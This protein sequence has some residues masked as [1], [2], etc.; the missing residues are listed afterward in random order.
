MISGRAEAYCELPDVTFGIAW[1]MAHFF[2]RRPGLWGS[3][4]G[5]KPQAG[6]GMLFYSYMRTAALEF[7]S[8]VLAEVEAEGLD[9]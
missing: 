9:S 1:A 4:G 5:R 6:K 2:E 8:G 3:S 7:I